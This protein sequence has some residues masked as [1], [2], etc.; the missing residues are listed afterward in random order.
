MDPALAQKVPHGRDAPAEVG[1]QP[2]TDHSQVSVG[3]IGA[4]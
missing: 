1:Y 4:G 3:L 2:A